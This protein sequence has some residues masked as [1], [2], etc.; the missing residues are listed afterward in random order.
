[1]QSTVTPASH[2]IDAHRIMKGLYQGAFPKSPQLLA[3]AGFDVVVF[4]AKEHQPAQSRFPNVY[5]IYCPLNDD[6]S[7]M[8]PEE[9]EWAQRTAHIVADLRRDGAKILVSCAMGINRS[10]LVSALTVH[11]LTGLPGSQCVEFVRSRRPGALTNSYFVR[12]LRN[13]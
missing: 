12:A 9:W 6:G 3:R 4:C 2:G 10:G 8:R 1:M 11:D 5:S 7:P 13:M